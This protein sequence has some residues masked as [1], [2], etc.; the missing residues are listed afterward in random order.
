MA[1]VFAALL[2]L[3]QTD[4]EAAGLEITILKSSD[5]KAYNDAID[6]FK[7]TSPGSAIFAEYDLLG[8][9]ERGKQLAKRIRTSESSLMDI[10]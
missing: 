5:L 3:P 6:G 2:W 9:L 4:L 8:D 1:L 7:A 10:Y